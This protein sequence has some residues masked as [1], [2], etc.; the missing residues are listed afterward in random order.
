MSR[1]AEAVKSLVRRLPPRVVFYGI[2]DSTSGQQMRSLS[3]IL[4]EAHGARIEYGPTRDPGTIHDIGKGLDNCVLF[5]STL[6]GEGGISRT[7]CDQGRVNN[8]GNGSA[9]ADPKDT[10]ASIVTKEAAAE[11]RTRDAHVVILIAMGA[12]VNCDDQE[13]HGWLEQATDLQSWWLKQ[14]YQNATLVFRDPLPQHFPNQDGRFKAGASSSAQLAIGSPRCIPVK[15]CVAAG[16]QAAKLNPEL[17]RG[18][19]LSQDHVFNS[20]FP[21]TIL[22]DRRTAGLRRLPAWGVSA[23]SASLHNN[24]AGDCTHYCV[25]LTSIWNWMLIYIVIEQTAGSVAANSE[26]GG[27]IEALIEESRQ[28]TA[29]DMAA[30]CMLVR[31]ANDLVCDAATEG[32]ILVGQRGK[33]EWDLDLGTDRDASRWVRVSPRM[34]PTS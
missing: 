7:V 31:S 14:N 1:H 24:R 30:Y 3:C 19:R 23:R 33:W 11:A 16:Q 22:L 28:A 2:G 26:G 4:E 6:P 20:S 12:W 29:T 25:A 10:I 21:D 5:S 27:A 8:L 9:W 13:C 18:G 34:R 32:T 17:I 15:N